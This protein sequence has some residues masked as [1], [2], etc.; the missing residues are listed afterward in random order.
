MWFYVSEFHLG[1]PIVFSC[2]V[3]SAVSLLTFQ[4]ILLLITLTVLR[5]TGYVFVVTCFGFFLMFILIYLSFLKYH[6]V[7]GPFYCTISGITGTPLTMA[8]V[9]LYPLA[10]Y[11]VYH[12]LHWKFTTFRPFAYVLLGMKYPWG[13]HT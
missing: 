11:R 6:R 9:D 2:H 1:W 10:C 8:D 12:F 3:F 5:R 7:K 4:S 13:I